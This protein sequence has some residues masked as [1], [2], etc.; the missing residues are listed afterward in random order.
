MRPTCYSLSLHTLMIT[1]SSEEATIYKHTQHSGPVRGLDFN[2]LQ[3]NLLAS[4]ATNGEVR[5]L[6]LTFISHAD[7]ST[8][9]HLGPNQP[10]KAL[11]ARQQVAKPRRHHLARMELERRPC[12]RYLILVRLHRCMGSQRKA[13]SR[14]AQLLGNGRQYAR[15]SAGVDG[16]WHADR[17]QRRNQR[18]VLAS[19]EC[20]RSLLVFRDVF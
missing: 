3:P 12:P 4:G 16:Q 20:A 10:S 9:L 17:S 19:G 2:K 11:L 7:I 18:R 5:L 14:R 15:R 13:R 1:H 8:D 6:F